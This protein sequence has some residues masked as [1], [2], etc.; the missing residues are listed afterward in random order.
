MKI[1]ATREQGQRRVLA[2]V[3]QSCD[4]RKR[5]SLSLVGNIGRMGSANKRS[6]RGGGK[7]RVDVDR[8]AGYDDCL[9]IAKKAFFPKGVSSE[10]HEDAPFP[11]KLR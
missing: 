11:W 9:Q 5:S 3:H 4:R 1:S 8:D 2:V 10:G 7:R 6:D